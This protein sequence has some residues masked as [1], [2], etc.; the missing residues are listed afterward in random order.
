MEER[1]SGGGSTH[2]NH[3]RYRDT[4]RRDR[5]RRTTDNIVQSVF[6]SVDVTCT[7]LT[8]CRVDRGSSYRKAKHLVLSATGYRLCP[9]GSTIPPPCPAR[10]V[11]DLPSRRLPNHPSPPQALHHSRHVQHIL[12]SLGV[13]FYTLEPF[14][15]LRPLD[16]RRLRSER[17]GKRGEVHRHALHGHPQ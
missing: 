6:W 14:I 9:D 5:V 13:T 17:P 15:R 16:D 7:P 12:D 11:P 8:W 10:R 1:Q 3:T 2:T 4:T